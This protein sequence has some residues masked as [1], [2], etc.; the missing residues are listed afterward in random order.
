MRSG[1]D[2]VMEFTF[3]AGIPVKTASNPDAIRPFAQTKK[4][5]KK[6]LLW[7]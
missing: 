3:L 6:L 1:A 7:A 4:F 2:R 5:L